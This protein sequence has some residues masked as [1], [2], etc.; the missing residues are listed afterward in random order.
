MNIFSVE[1]TTSA[2]HALV[3]FM[4]NIIFLIS[5][6]CYLNVFV[7]LKKNI[8]HSIFNLIKRYYIRYS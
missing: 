2:G 6:L 8:V 4:K 1:K 5:I 7:N 3:I